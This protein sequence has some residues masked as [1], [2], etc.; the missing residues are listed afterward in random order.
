MR[1]AGPAPVQSF[2]QTMP[3]SLGFAGV[4]AHSIAGRLHDASA[5]IALGL[6]LLRS[7]PPGVSSRGSQAVAMLYQALGDLKQLEADVRRETSPRPA[8]DLVPELHR[9]AALLGL[10]LDL[11]AAGTIDELEPCFADLLDLVGREALIN[12]RRHSG[13]RACEID[14]DFTVV[15][16]VLRARD[17]GIGPG[18]RPEAGRGLSMLRDMARWLGCELT[19]ASPPGFGTELILIGPQR[20]VLLGDAATEPSPQEVASS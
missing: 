11:R 1:T 6:G 3:R 9:Q 17:R 20:V 14:L 15:P 12:V 2:G 19:I 13:V 16:F 8:R 10:A 7:K 18:S 4:D 5:E